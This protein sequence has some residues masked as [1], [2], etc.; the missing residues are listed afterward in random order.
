V[1]SGS[2]R[3]TLRVGYTKDRQAFGVP[4]AS[5]QVIAHGLA[6]IATDLDGA[7][8][9]SWE[10]AWARDELPRR[11]AELSSMAYLIAVEAARSATEGSL[12]LFGGYGFMLEYDVQLYFRNAKAWGLLLGDAS[13]EADVLAD[14]LWTE[15]G[16]RRTSTSNQR[17]LSFAPTCAHSWPST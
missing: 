14:I 16:R 12:H 15:G 13:H 10:A 1:G 2:A 5:F 3:S 8:L 6:D 4:I 9:L 7:K 11:A 17:R